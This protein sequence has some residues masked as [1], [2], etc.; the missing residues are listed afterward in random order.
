MDINIIYIL[1]CVIL[2]WSFWTW[3]VVPFTR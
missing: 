2:W 3:S 1:N